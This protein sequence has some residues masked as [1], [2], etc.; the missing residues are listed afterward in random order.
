M[1]DHTPKTPDPTPRSE[2]PPH[3]TPTETPTP[4]T[5]EQGKSGTRDEPRRI[6]TEEGDGD[7]LVRNW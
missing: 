2:Q 4:D 1:D 5:A 6:R 7:E 3:D